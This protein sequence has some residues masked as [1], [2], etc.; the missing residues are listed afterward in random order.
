MKKFWLAC[1]MV[2]AV[3]ISSCVDSDKDL[4]Q[5]APEKESNTNDFSTEKSVQVDID[6][7]LTKAKV[8]FLIYDEN[9][10]KVVNDANGNPTSACTFNE[11]IKPLDGAWTDDEGKYN[12]KM[13]L[14]AYVSKVYIVSKAFYATRLIEGEIVN[15]VLK[16]TEPEY[17]ELAETRAFGNNSVNKDP[18]RFKKLGWSTQLGK[19]DS[20]TGQIKYAYTKN[21]PKLVFT[22]KERKEFCQT[23]Y[24]V[25]NTLGSC[26]DDYRKSNDLY[27]TGDNENNLTDIVLTSLGGW[28]CWNSSLGYYYYK[29]GN[30][31]Q[32][33]DEIKVFT[34]FP[35][36]QTTWNNY[37]A[38]GKLYASPRGLTE[39]TSV[40]LKFFGENY[41]QNEGTAFP[42]GYRIGFVLAC[43][44]W[45]Y[46][47]VGF[48]AHSQ[49]NNYISCSTAGLSSKGA[50][51]IDVH[52][53]MF[54]DQNGNI[55]ICFEDFKDDENFTDV[56]FALKANPIIADGLPD[57]NP[58][59]DTTIEKSGVYAFEDEWP[60]AG[61]YDMNDVLVQYTYQKT[62]NIR[63][64]ILN[65]S[66]AF[67]TFFNKRTVFTNGLGFT[68]TN[69]GNSEKTEYLI[70]KEGENEFSPASGTDKITSDGN[71]IILTDNVKTNQN[72][73]YKITRE[74]NESTKKQETTIDAFI[75]R[76]SKGDTRLEVHCPM[77]KPTSKVDASLFGQ[78]DDRSVPDKGIYYISDKENIYPF[79]F[80]LS[81]AN[82]NDIEKL[83]NF[84]QNE[85]KAI[86]ELYPD[87]INW[88][89]YGKNPDWYKKK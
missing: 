23:I 44:A 38:G 66:F 5:E 46:K 30:T 72:A 3:G 12:E 11:D 58:D 17:K 28:T 51:N 36:T 24:S 25:L 73:E 16:V 86:S 35:N 61:D 54:K 68:L 56:L 26:P 37:D 52:T 4:Y 62:F 19:Y 6:Y 53:A 43:N 39:G 64:N 82:I 78:Y 67:K 49:T 31:P 47:F 41:D 21:D 76:P 65:E 42:K 59:L 22:E 10:I 45:D 74:Y 7:S 70:K 27:I 63:N 1:T 88:A 8:P 14:P 48:N 34:V 20:S 87:F 50:N 80:Y 13:T 57:V 79:A 71:V 77:Q 69:E 33:L 81:N 84:D 9:P 18:N 60:K 85:R 55:A 15:G 29:D 40:Q 83:K 75:Y 32:S 89:K 2:I